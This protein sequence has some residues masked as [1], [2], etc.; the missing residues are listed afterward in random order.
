MKSIENI[1]N[2]GFGSIGQALIELLAH[3]YSCTI[4][5]FEKDVDPTK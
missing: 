3:R 4:T 5:I 2:V 1:V